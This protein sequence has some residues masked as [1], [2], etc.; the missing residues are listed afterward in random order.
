MMKSMRL[1]HSL[2]LFSEHESILNFH[3]AQKA[4][5]TALR[6]HCVEAAAAQRLTAAAAALLTTA[7]AASL[8]CWCV[9]GGTMAP[10]KA[11]EGAY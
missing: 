6:A 3:S 9:L 10:R 4:A 1:D 11:E 2:C 7:A 5:A 8:C